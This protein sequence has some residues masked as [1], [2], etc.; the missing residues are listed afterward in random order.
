LE[1]TGGGDAPEAYELALREARKL[2]WTKGYS[3]ALVIIGDEVPHCPSYT[4]EKINWFDEVVDIIF[5]M[6]NL[7]RTNWWKW[8]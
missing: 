2:S 3:K 5:Y 8:E 7:L 4:T 6:G 1:A